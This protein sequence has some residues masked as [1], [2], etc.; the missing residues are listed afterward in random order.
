M[1]QLAKARKV[2]V[3][4]GRAIFDD[5]TTLRVETDQKQIMVEFEHA[6]IATGSQ[7][8]I[9]SVFNLGS[10]RVMSSTEAL[11]LQDVPKKLMVIGGGYIG[12]ELG[13]VYAGLGSE[14]VMVEAM[15]DILLGA[16]RDLV[17][18]VKSRANTLFKELRLDT[19]VKSL[20][21]KGKQVAVTC[22]LPDGKTKTENYDRVLVSIG[23]VPNVDDLGLK[24]IGIDQ[25]EKNFIKVNDQ[26]ETSVAN[27]YAIGDVAGG[28][29]LAHK[30]SKEARVAVE[31]ILGHN[32]TSS[33]WVM[34]AVVFTSPELA[35][36][37]LTEEEAREKGISVKVSKFPWA[38]SGRAKTL[39]ADHGLTKLIIEKETDRVLGIGIVGK[40]AG[41]LISEGT[42][43]IEMGA[44]AKDLA[45]TIHP[46][47]T[48]SETVMEC[49]ESI[50]GVATHIISKRQ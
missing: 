4:Q 31:H 37:G 46:H 25:D 27:I 15:K 21:T 14:I 22:F 2:Q 13:F 24:D 19:K 41:E 39:D 18:P 50:Y 28:I 16:D 45:E 33:Q 38:A 36:S 30:A 23:R 32:V 49:A 35:W 5:Q 48:L 3:I 7:P 34:P 10:K 44:T 9:P 11:E 1:S 43:A 17:R 20:A 47:P 6:I 26:C 42:L 40:G 8:N 29:L 12:M